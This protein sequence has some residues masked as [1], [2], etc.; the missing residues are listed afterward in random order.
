MSDISSVEVFDSSKYEDSSSQMGSQKSDTQNE[1]T[2]ERKLIFF[3]ERKE[4]VILELSS[5][6]VIGR[7]AKGT[8][9]FQKLDNPKVISRLHCQVFFKD[10]QWFIRDMDSTNNTFLN[11]NRL[12]ANK[13]YELKKGDIINLAGVIEFEVL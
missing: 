3:K 2:K 5:G 4:G 7:I 9:I 12:I 8:E 6:D 11:G 10:N 13:E 1:S